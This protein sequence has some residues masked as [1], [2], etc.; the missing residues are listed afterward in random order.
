MVR[1]LIA[2]LTVGGY[3]FKGDGVAGRRP[4]RRVR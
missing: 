2:W 3:E 4:L 1:A